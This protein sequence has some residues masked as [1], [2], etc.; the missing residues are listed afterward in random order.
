MTST[1]FA[2]KLNVV[3][4]IVGS[5]GVAQSAPAAE[6]AP[7]PA[8]A[9]YEIRFMS[10]MIDHH[11]MAI[12]M[13]EMCVDRAIHAELEALCME[14]IETQTAE[15]ETMQAWLRDWYRVD[16]EPD[17]RQPMKRLANLGGAEFEVVF[18]EMMI[19]HHARA[20]REGSR[21]VERAYHPELIQMCEAIV[22][23]QIEEIRILRTWL[24]DWYGSCEPR[25]PAVN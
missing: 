12:M 22:G 8:T 25:F 24:C 17:V 6:P 16:H 3:I 1:G 18:M 21:C 20:V 7:D 23:T 4:A 10:K 9:K 11:A 2:Y 15:I 13:A 14:I 5:L 19:R